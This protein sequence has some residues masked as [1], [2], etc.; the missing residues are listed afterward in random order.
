[1]YIKT[2]QH[3]SYQQATNITSQ[4]QQQQ[5]QQQLQIKSNSPESG[6]STPNSNITKKLVY[7]V[8]V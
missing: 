2:F 3:P 7:E 1:M 5:Q 6:Y 8:I 4:Q